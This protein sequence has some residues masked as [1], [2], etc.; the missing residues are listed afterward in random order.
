MITLHSVNVTKWK[1]GTPRQL[2]HNISF[3]VPQKRVTLL[4]GKSGSGK[5][6]ILRC[7]SQLETGYQGEITWQGKSIRLFTHKER[8]QLLGFVAQSYALF[9]FLTVL[10][11]CAQPLRIVLGLS[12]EEAKGKV[13]A[14]LHSLEMHHLSH[15][16]PHELSG[17]QQQ[18]TAIVR[19]LVLNPDYLLLDEPTSALDPDN[20]DLLIDIIQKLKAEGRGI[21]ISSQDMRFASKIFDR[22]YFLEGGRIIESHDPDPSS[23]HSLAPESKLSRFLFPA[24]QKEPA[25]I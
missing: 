7:I 13:E 12:K 14:L 11:N 19:A 8:C 15:F 16:Y 10:E 2:L 6:T 20:V 17:G 18:R 22:I 9:P 1:K 23:R 24:E 3:Q 5:T 21:I 4:L 25:S